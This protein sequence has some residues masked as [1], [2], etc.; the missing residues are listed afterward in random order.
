MCLCC[1]LISAKVSHEIGHT[2]KEPPNREQLPSGRQVAD[3]AL[4]WGANDKRNK[5]NHTQK[6][7]DFSWQMTLLASVPCADDNQMFE[8]EFCTLQCSN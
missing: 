6:G 3:A 1:E 4:G 7:S 8:R 2:G 5:F